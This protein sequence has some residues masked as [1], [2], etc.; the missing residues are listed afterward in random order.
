MLNITDIR[1]KKVEGGGKMK[2][3]ASITLDDAFV[4]HDIKIVEGYNGV[5][6][7]MPSRRLP[8]GDFRDIAHPINADSRAFLQKKI[9]SAYEG[10]EEIKK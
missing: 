1:I 2:A 4:I 6:V 7:A 5:F 8:D 10:L 9:F 3:I